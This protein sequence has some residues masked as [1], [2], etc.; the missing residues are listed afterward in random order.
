MFE[1]R[2][3]REKLFTIPEVAR[4]LRVHPTTLYRLIRAGKFPGFKVGD[5]WRVNAE[6]FERWVKR[7]DNGKPNTRGRSR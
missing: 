1:D 6:S 3:H 4:M 2:I 7:T 5:S